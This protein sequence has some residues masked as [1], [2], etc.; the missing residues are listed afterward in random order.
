MA[1]VRSPRVVY[2]AVW[3]AAV[4]CAA[5]TT[6]VAGYALSDGDGDAQFVTAAQ[7]GGMAAAWAAVLTGVALAGAGVWAAVQARKPPR[8]LV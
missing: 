4:L 8:G 3:V 7:A 2:L 6:A 5:L 1:A